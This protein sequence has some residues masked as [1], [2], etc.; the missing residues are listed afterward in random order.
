[1]RPLTAI[2]FLNS[3]TATRPSSAWRR[4]SKEFAALYRSLAV[5]SDVIERNLT[6]KN[7][8]T[9]WND[10]L[11]SIGNEKCVQWGDLYAVPFIA[12]SLKKQL[13]LKQ[14]LEKIETQQFKIFN[15]VVCLWIRS[16]QEPDR[17]RSCQTRLPR[18]QFVPLALLL[19]S[20]GKDLPFD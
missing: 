16:K 9:I 5:D 1:M 15:N 11:P 4:H 2:S 14:K 6:R 19:L 3:T 20:N 8:W 13:V 10:F 12:L 18:V 17:T 7:L